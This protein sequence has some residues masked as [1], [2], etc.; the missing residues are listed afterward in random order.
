MP[1]TMSPTAE[2]LEEARKLATLNDGWMTPVDDHISLDAMKDYGE[3]EC[4][5]HAKWEE[6]CH[7]DLCYGSQLREIGYRDAYAQGFDEKN[8][9]EAGL[10]FHECFYV[11]LKEA[12]WEQWS[13]IHDLYDFWDR[14]VRPQQYPDRQLRLVFA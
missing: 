7:F 8:H 12:F 6:T 3:F 13:E 2:A 4:D 5:Q 11:P 1:V 10:Y 9:R 14:K